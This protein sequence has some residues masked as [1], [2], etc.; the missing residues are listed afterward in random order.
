[1]EEDRT[2]DGGEQRGIAQRMEV[3]EGESKWDGGEERDCK[4][5]GGEIRTR[6]RKG[7]YLDGG[8][9]RVL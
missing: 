3:R 6:R 9:E 5:G 7:H 1:M 2:R 4:R 8:E